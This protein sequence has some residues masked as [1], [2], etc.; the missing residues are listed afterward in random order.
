MSWMWTKD[1]SG[2]PV[3][4]IKLNMVQIKE[5]TALPHGKMWFRL[6]ESCDFM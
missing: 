5:E 3:A 2:H 1:Q 6:T 4:T